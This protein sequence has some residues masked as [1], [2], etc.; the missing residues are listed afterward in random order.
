MTPMSSSSDA[1]VIESI[2]KHERDTVEADLARD[3]SFVRDYFH[4]DWTH[5]NSL[6]KWDTKQAV[7]ADMQDPTCKMNS[8][9]VSDVKVRV[10]DNAAVA[11]STTTYDCVVHG[12]HRARTIISTATFIRQ[13]GVWQQVARHSSE[14]A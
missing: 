4:E 1:A 6:G 8:E 11:T 10:Y 12:Q 13:N 14:K 7:L 5:G 2:I 3:H 9:S